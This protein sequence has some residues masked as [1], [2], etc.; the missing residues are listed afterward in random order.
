MFKKSVLACLFAFGVINQAI[1]QECLTTNWTRVSYNYFLEIVK[2]S[3]TKRVN[4]KIIEERFTKTEDRFATPIYIRKFLCDNGIKI[5]YTWAPSLSF[6]VWDFSDKTGKFFSINSI[7]QADG[8]SSS[9]Q[10]VYNKDCKEK[11]ILITHFLQFASSENVEQGTLLYLYEEGIE[12]GKL[13][14]R[15][16]F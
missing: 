16:I 10:I 7:K 5:F 9:I 13:K 15:P 3:G 8:R 4:C 1:A 6:T 2:P 14:I 11:M 12:R